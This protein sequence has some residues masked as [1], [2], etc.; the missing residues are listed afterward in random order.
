M[1][2]IGQ[3]KE[4]A[5]NDQQHD[6]PPRQKVKPGDRKAEGQSGNAKAREQ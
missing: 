2:E 5:A 1:P 6:D 3:R 4:G